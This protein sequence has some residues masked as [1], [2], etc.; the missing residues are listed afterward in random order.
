[1]SLFS[2]FPGSI[3]VS[4]VIA[5][6]LTDVNTTAYSL[7][8]SIFNSTTYDYSGY[9]LTLAP[10]LTINNATYYGVTCGDLVSLHS[11]SV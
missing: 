9:S 1:M 3:V 8:D 10:Y 6:T 7:C 11:G 5:G 4:F 2:L